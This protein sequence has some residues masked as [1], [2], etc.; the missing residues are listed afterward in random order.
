M[1]VIYVIYAESHEESV[2]Y[3][4]N[5]IENAKKRFNKIVKKNHYS[6]VRLERWRLVHNSGVLMDCYYDEL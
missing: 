4:E 5:D 6:S 3:L 1:E 2:R